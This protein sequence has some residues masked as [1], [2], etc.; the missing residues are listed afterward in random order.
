[1]QV[2][3][4]QGSLEPLSDSHASLLEAAVRQQLRKILASPE[5]QAS[6]MLRDF[7]AFIVEQTLAGHAQEIKGYTVA[8]QVLGR[9]ANFDAGKDPIVRILAGRLRRALERY[10]S[11]QGR[12][13]PMRIDIPKGAYVPMFQ[14]VLGDERSGLAD[15]VLALPSGPA[16]AVMPLLNLTGDRKQ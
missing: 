2:H 4:E 14:E 11:T 7:L 6:A 13:D 16:M 8:T 9:K 5:F 1:M 3:L 12:Q 10:Y 15:A